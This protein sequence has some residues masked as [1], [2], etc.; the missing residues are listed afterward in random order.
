MYNDVDDHELINNIKGDALLQ[1]TLKTYIHDNKMDFQD[2]GIKE[3]FHSSGE[4]EL[5]MRMAAKDI[6]KNF[7]NKEK[8][9]SMPSCVQKLT[10][11]SVPSKV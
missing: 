9:R 4:Y 3:I 2:M 6:Y 11:T 10:K 8:I 5:V 1:V 7:E